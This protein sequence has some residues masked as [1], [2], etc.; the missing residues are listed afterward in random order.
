MT[1]AN[2]I[3]VMTSI[4]LAHI[5]KKTCFCLYVKRLDLLCYPSGSKPLGLSDSPASECQVAG[6]TG[7]YQGILAKI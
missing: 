4:A 3:S 5:I 6:T 1:L 2:K 7:T